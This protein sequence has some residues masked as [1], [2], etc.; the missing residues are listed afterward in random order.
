MTSD[1]TDFENEA[2]DILG[3][4]LKAAQGAAEF[5]VAEKRAI[6]VLDPLLPQPLERVG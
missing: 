1:D 6:H 4:C 5:R 2:A 3:H